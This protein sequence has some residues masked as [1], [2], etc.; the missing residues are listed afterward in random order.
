MKRILVNATQPE[1]L[2]VAIVD[3]QKLHDL[4]IEVGSRE[5]R[6][7]NV[8]KGR[9]TRVEPSLEAAF[10]D[11]GGN[12][13]GFLPLKEVAKSYYEKADG[14][15]KA[16]LSEGQE[17]IVQVEKE[18]RGN[19]GA[20]L[21]TYIS[22]A[23]RYLV[24][25]PNNP[26]AGGV[27]RRI[28]GEERN[29]LREALNEVQVPE[30]MGVIV[31]TAG[32]GRC[33]EELQWD[34]DYLAHVWK[35]IND[36]ADARKAPF[37]IYQESNVI[38]RALRDYLR[39]D[40]GEVVIDQPEVYETGREFMQQVMPHALNKLKQYT[41]ETP[42]F[43]RFQVESQIE[44]AF[45]REVTLPSGG[46]IVIDHTEAMTSV[47]INS[48]RATK[49]AGIEE[50]AFN[51]NVE[52]AEEVARQL[53]IRDLGGLVVIDFIDMESAKNQRE[54]EN[55]LKQAAKAD[56][57]RVQIGRISRFG[58][59]EMS[60]QRLKP[61][62]SE[63]SSQVCPRCLGRGSIRSVESL[64][65]S[66]LR[67]LEEEA[68]KPGTGRVIVQLPIPVASFLLNEK[69]SD[70]ADVERRAKTRITLVPN[71]ELETPH[72]EIRRVR[73]DQL[74]EEDNNAASYKIDTQV[75]I[76]KPAEPDHQASTRKAR[77]EPAVKRVARP[78]APVIER[79]EP[80]STTAG[81]S[82]PP[83]AATP[84]PA[85][86]MTPW[87][88]LWDALRRIFSGEAD[89]GASGSGP[90]SRET[91]TQKTEHDQRRR[92][93]D[94]KSGDESAGRR[95][96]SGDGNAKTNARGD[97]SRNDDNNR[98]TGNSRSGNSRNGNRRR[99]GRNRS[100]DEDSNGQSSKQSPGQNAD[101]AAP[102]QDAG[103]SDKPAEDTAQSNRDKAAAARKDADNSRSKAAEAQAKQSAQGNKR[104][105]NS[106]SRKPEPKT[107]DADQ[108]SDEP[109]RTNNDASGA[110]DNTGSGEAKRGRRRRRGGRGRRGGRK[111]GGGTDNDTDE[112]KAATTSDT[113]NGAASTED[114]ASGADQHAQAAQ[115]RPRSDAGEAEMAGGDDDNTPAA[116]R[117]AEGSADTSSK[118]NRGD[119]Q[120][121]EDRPDRGADG[122][123]GTKRQPRATLP[124]VEDKPWS[125]VTASDNA[126]SASQND[127]DTPAA[128]KTE[129]EGGKPDKPKRRRRAKASSAA[130][131]A[132][133][134]PGEDAPS[135]PAAG[136]DDGTTAD[137]SEIADKPRK[138]KPKRRRSTAS[139]A[140]A[141]EDTDGQA[142]APAEPNKT[143]QEA[144]AASAEESAAV[145]ESGEAAGK[146][147]DT[148]AT[149]A[150]PD[151]SSASQTPSAR[152]DD[153]TPATNAH[154]VKA[155]EA[156]HASDTAS[157]TGA[158]QPGN[159][160]RAR[161]QQVETSAAAT[162]QPETEDRVADASTEAAH[163]EAATASA[164]DEPV[165]A[166]ATRVAASAVV[167]AA[168]PAEPELTQ[169]E[170]RSEQAPHA[171]HGADT[172]AGTT[173]QD[174]EKTQPDDT[175][176]A[177]ADKAD[178]SPEKP[179]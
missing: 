173:T 71:N 139:K 104:A 15:G 138:S 36:A 64:S 58:L 161:L 78:D 27:S 56:R 90:A 35:A 63:Y 81:A 176:A 162:S 135:A 155:D 118:R 119:A 41:D 147:V 101:K 79:S 164:D 49:G 83:P 178:E 167:E 98:G 117:K 33:A 100:R 52:A 95:A 17:V 120:A 50:T 1:E 34:L 30:G 42:L 18:E 127:N 67:L 77:E 125:A 109:N 121:S 8:Y 99:G 80:A 132:D 94:A 110:D 143:P 160:E 12:R 171:A 86:T 113:A 157:P 21:T 45:E 175:P 112:Q 106:A 6:K 129:P 93:A 142:A 130:D 23:G 159:D 165:A 22:L 145:S 84:E 85:A 53:R 122:Q 158:T 59:L 4:D 153:V 72:Y 48:A 136:Q 39:D 170:T 133:A 74:T 166:A 128:P 69:R 43:S 10:I 32:V 108:A 65:L 141:S 31:R 151:A 89:L 150:T 177:S 47:D 82:T 25:M 29:E 115:T 111:R 134:T 73:G 61:S 116:D 46:S 96:E 5:Q 179:R 87:Q 154:E 3:G 126:R 62:L 123:N 26:R 144:P 97:K 172:E 114:E 91:T 107:D 44:S 20:A 66:I 169:V 102:K 105:D 76:E 38:I 60:R 54:V 2:R 152:V 103:K 131:T 7:A 163:D 140:A 16:T 149:A 19:K 40:I 168:S 146:P 156:G 51:T 11:Y 14:N 13:H 88:Q 57:A 148:P 75:D 137:S 174:G 24:L 92:G 68:M 28:E 124:E 9:V 55:R 70:L 37:L